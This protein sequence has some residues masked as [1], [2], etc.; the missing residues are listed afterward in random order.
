VNQLRFFGRLPLTRF[1][2][3]TYRADYSIEES[4]FL[5]NQ[6]GVE[7]ISKCLC[8]AIRAEFE[9]D[10]SDGFQFQLAYRIIGLGQD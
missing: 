6:L 9:Q 8:W 5:T 2:A 1:W 3:V 10:R 7:Y 4:F